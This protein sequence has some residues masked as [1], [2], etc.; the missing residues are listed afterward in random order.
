MPGGVENVG[1]ETVEWLDTETHAA[2]GSGVTAQLQAF[3]AP[4]HARL[5][6]RLCHHMRRTRGKHQRVA[7]ERAAHHIGTQRLCD[8]RAVA[9]VVLTGLAFGSIVTGQVA[10]HVD[11]GGE[12]HAQTRI[13]QRT[14]G[15]GQVQLARF[16]HQHFGEVIAGRLPAVKLGKVCRRE[17]SVVLHRNDADRVHE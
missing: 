9:Q 15:G 8:F 12:H 17:R 4:V 3:D 13:G 6:Q 10:V 16:G 5:A 11:A 1:L 14:T 2:G 7:I